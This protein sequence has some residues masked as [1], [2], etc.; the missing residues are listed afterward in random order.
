VNPDQLLAAYAAARVKASTEAAEAAGSSG[1]SLSHLQ[2]PE[3]NT[4]RQSVLS[5][6]SAYSNAGPTDTV[7]R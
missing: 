4:T 3:D 5:E 6:A 1:A 7:R 2:A